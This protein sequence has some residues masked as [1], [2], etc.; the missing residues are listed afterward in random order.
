MTSIGGDASNVLQKVPLLSV[1]AEGNVSLRGSTNV[2]IL[3]NGK[4]S[5]MFSSNVAD[6]L[7]SIP[8]DQIKS[9]EVITSPT[10][11]YDGEGSSGIINIITK[12]QSAQGFTGSVN[13]S[14]G[15]R[16]NRGSLSL[17]LTRGRF[18]VNFNGS[19]WYNPNRPSYSEEFRLN[20]LTKVRSRKMV[21]AKVRFMVHA[22]A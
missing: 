9:V 3:I 19:G 7:K 2:Q 6:A 22:P 1:D 14:V 21:A 16:S 5:T 17:N 13:G 10:A 12:K 8:A 11:K 4:P 20:K 18:G 15:N